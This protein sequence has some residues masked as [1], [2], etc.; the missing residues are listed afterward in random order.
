MITFERLKELVLYNE[1]TGNFTWKSPRT[2]VKVGAVA[3]CIKEGEYTQLMLDNVNYSAHRLVWLYMT[4]EWPNVGDH[5][6]R[7]K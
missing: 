2:G 5:I 3:G 7:D 6:N 4:G 1:F